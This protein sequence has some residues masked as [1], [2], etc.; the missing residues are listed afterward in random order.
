MERNN[1]TYRDTDTVY[2]VYEEYDDNRRLLNVYENLDD[3]KQEVDNRAREHTYEPNRERG[4]Y[5]E[6]VDHGMLFG[7]WVDE[8]DF[9]TGDER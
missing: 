6:L 1:I 5:S 2:A 9:V 4:V 3:A 7:Y 8:V